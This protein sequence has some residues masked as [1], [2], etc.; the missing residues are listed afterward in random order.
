MWYRLMVDECRF[1]A[2]SLNSST[3]VAGRS[4]GIR[5]AA[6]FSQDPSSVRLV[7]APD[8]EVRELLRI[9]IDP[10]GNAKNASI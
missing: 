5:R 9:R 8:I 10:E 4:S 7:V 6:K 1:R 3:V 2:N